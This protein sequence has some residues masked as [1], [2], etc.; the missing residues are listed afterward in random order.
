MA[1]PSDERIFTSEVFFDRK[2][3]QGGR[4]DLGKL[5]EP[6]R[7]IPVYRACDVLVVGGGP[8]GTAAAVAAARLG[9]DVILLERYNHLGGLSTGGLV[10][11]IDRM[12]DWTGQLVIRGFAEEIMAR[13]PK[14]AVA[15]P[16]RREWG[17]REPARAEYWAQRTSA[18]HGVVTWAPTVDPERLKLASQE[19]VL[20]AKGRLV[21]HCWAALPLMEEGKVRG[22]VFESKAG[23][24][25]V[26]AKVVVDA[27]GDGDLFARAG[28]A[29]E[30]D[31]DQEDIHHCMNTPWLFGGV[32]MERWLEFRGGQP[33]AYAAFMARGREAMRLFDKPFVSWRNDVA[34]FMGPRQSGFSALD[35]DE[36]TEVE[37]RSHRLM[38]RHLDFYRAQAPG[39]EN[40]FLLQSAPQL[41]VRHARRLRG[42]ARIERAQWPLGRTFADEVAVSPSVSPKFPNISVPYGSLVPAAL[43]GLLACGRHISCDPNSHSFMREIPQCWLTGH[44]AGAAAA[45]A[46][47]R[48][49]EPRS[50]DIA[51]LQAA[52]IRQ[53]AFVRPAESRAAAAG[54]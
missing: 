20:E 53:G 12:T 21:Y 28:A 18:Y 46:A 27:T 29:F 33:E 10:I 25:A 16:E 22:A 41:G 8:S 42:V 2:S 38:A 35:M 5:K 51:E 47:N 31:I 30:S 4:P 43:D 11:W 48:G 32:D 52:L 26:R 1:S 49:L 50:V 3:D 17:S 23:R 24:Q 19:M 6:A 45:I 34:L 54:A 14:D 36:Q 40:A 15:G 7:D 9:A 39:F 44:A 13:L 37:I